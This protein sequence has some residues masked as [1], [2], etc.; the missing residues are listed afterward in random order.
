[1]IPLIVVAVQILTDGWKVELS[2][3]GMICI[4]DTFTKYHMTMV[5]I[6]IMYIQLNMIKER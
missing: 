6:G 5:Y 2:V 3:L 1:M 4:L